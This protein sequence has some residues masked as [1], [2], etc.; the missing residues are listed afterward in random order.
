MHRIY[1]LWERTVPKICETYAFAN[2][3]AEL[4]FQA[5]PP[6]PAKGNPNSLGF[7]P[8]SSPEKDLVFLQFMFFFGDVGATE[9]LNTALNDLIRMVDKVAEEEGVK[10][11]YLYLNFAAW[12][13]D[14]FAGYGREQVRKLRHVAKKYD[15]EGFFQK[16]VYR[17]F[18][19]F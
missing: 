16:Q 5:L 14:P 7:A 11:D 9:G 17:G 1:D 8:N 6:L 18:K 19:L 4:T 2:T 15:P 10:E 12:F 3:A 13:Q